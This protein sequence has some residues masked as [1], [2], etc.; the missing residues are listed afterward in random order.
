MINDAELGLS[1]ENSDA[2]LVHCAKL[3]EGKKAILA[4]TGLHKTQGGSSSSGGGRTKREDSSS[5]G[6]CGL[7]GLGF[8]RGLSG[9]SRN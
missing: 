8:S 7:R 4:V 2:I 5:G 6:G 9:G 3:M 1:R